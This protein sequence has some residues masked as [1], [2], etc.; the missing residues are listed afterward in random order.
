M[1][2]RR[3]TPTVAD[4]LRTLLEFMTDDLPAIAHARIAPDGFDPWREAFRIIQA[5]EIWQTFGELCAP[6]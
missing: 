3:P 5:Y 6:A 2:S 1:P 4:L